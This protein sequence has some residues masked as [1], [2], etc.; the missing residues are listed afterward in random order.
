VLECDRGINDNNK[1]NSS[2]NNNIHLNNINHSMSSWD[3]GERE[4]DKDYDDEVNDD[5]DFHEDISD[6][7]YE[8]IKLCH[9]HHKSSYYDIQST[10]AKITQLEGIILS[11]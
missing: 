11:V 1:D 3:G 2:N 7:D 8:F 4:R 6:G 9:L 10:F 5:V